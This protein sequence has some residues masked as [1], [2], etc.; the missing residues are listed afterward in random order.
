MKT[1]FL[2]ALIYAL[3]TTQWQSV[4]AQDIHSSIFSAVGAM[5]VWYWCRFRR[6]TS[7]R[8]RRRMRYLPGVTC[9]FCWLWKCLDQCLV[10][11]ERKSHCT[12]QRMVNYEYI[13]YGIYLCRCSY[14]SPPWPWYIATVWVPCYRWRV[15]RVCLVNE[16]HV[17]VDLPSQLVSVVTRS[18]RSFSRIPRISCV[19]HGYRWKQ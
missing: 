5:L 8:W 19:E 13:V 14:L 12:G 18:A 2:W 10:Y 4:F 3:P 9:S 16:L 15:L 11:G 6:Y 1:C 17:K 7:C